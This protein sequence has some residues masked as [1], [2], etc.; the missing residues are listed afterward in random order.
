MAALLLAT[1]FAVLGA[2][3]LHGLHRARLAWIAWRHRESPVPARA[4]TRPVLVQLPLYNE[5]FVAERVMRA[6]AALRFPEGGV[7]QVL[8]DSTDETRAVVDRVARELRTAGVDVEVVRRSDRTG[9]KAGALAEGLRRRPD[10]E[11]VAI[12]DAD[13]MPRP[14]F[15]EQALP[16]LLAADDIGL[17]QARWGHLNRDASLLTRAQAVFLD[18]HFAVEHAARM[19][20]GHPFNFNGTAGL[21]RRA[22]IDEAGGWQG[23]TITEDLDLSYRAQMKGWRFVYAHDLVAPAELPESW[24]AFRAQQ[25]RWTRGSV[26]T[27]RKLLGSVLRAEKLTLGARIDAAIHLTSNFAYLL[28]AALAVL[29]PAA[30]VLRE[31]LGWRVPGGRLLLSGMDMSTLGAGTLA[32][33]AFYL[34]ALARTGAGPVRRIGDVLFALCLGA[35][36]SLSNAREILRGL[37]SRS[38]EFV[39]TPKKGDFASASPGA[40]LESGG[41]G[42][43]AGAPKAVGGYRARS[44]PWLIVIELGFA[45]YFAAGLVYAMTWRVWGAMPFL[46]LYLLGFSTVALRSAFEALGPRTQSA[47]VPAD[48]QLAERA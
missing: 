32:V 2:L 6:A 8:D 43:A 9:Y 13:F 30:L 21:W 34:V 29:L 26:E 36:M 37:R 1:Y 41:T 20:L 45:G 24:T 46:I 31:E 5:A 33:T 27:A 39:R 42:D 15:V 4:A 38:S 25:A 16:R 22:A 47:P 14:D 48:P 40:A 28:M 12:F 44:K 17:V 19:Q 35:G 3:S 23:D 18:G 10:A 11:V 7:V